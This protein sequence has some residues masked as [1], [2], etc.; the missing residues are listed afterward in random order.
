MIRQDDILLNN[1][2]EIPFEEYG[3]ALFDIQ[4]LAVMYGTNT[5]KREHFIME[6]DNWIKA[7]TIL[8]NTKIMN[9][10]RLCQDSGLPYRLVIEN[11]TH[12]LH[13]LRKLQED[14]LQLLYLYNPET[15]KHHF[16]VA[17][18]NDNVTYD[19]LGNSVTVQAYK[20]GVAFIESRRV[21]RRIKR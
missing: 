7:G 4:Y 1:M 6:C 14:E 21:F 17:D 12:K 2:S 13:A 3:C 18:E 5:F 20:R 8:P 16:V 10:D 11:R 9:W 15:G 19:S